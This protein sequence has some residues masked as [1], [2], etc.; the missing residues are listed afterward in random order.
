MTVIVL[1]LSSYASSMNIL[2]E[3]GSKPIKFITVK[4]ETNLMSHS[5]SGIHQSR[6][7]TNALLSR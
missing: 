6:A 5:Q 1:T 3:R 7:L 2:A 4:C